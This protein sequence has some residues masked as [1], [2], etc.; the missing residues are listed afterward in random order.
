MVEAIMPM[1]N[2]TVCGFADLESDR[3]LVSSACGSG[4]A[5]TCLVN[6]GPHSECPIAL[7]GVQLYARQH[8]DEND[9]EHGFVEVTR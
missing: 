9:G 2:R 8:P 6:Y 1:P 4:Y 3:C 7:L 5:L